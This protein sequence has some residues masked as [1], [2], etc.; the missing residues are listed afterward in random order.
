M[1]LG[2]SIFFLFMVILMI[3]LHINGGF[4]SHPMVDDEVVT[5]HTTV[6]TTTVETPTVVETP[7][8]WLPPVYAGDLKREFDGKQPFVIDPVDGEKWMLN[9]TDDQYEDAAGKMWRLV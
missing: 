8:H 9:T 5:T 4:Y 1:L 6:T 2:F 3:F 7:T